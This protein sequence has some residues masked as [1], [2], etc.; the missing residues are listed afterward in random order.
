MTYD[1]DV[2]NLHVSLPSKSMQREVFSNFGWAV[3]GTIPPSLSFSLV[4]TR[5]KYF[6]WF[7]GFLL[8]LVQYPVLG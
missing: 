3:I 7:C 5:F 8:V 6:A 1:H 2:L 4:C